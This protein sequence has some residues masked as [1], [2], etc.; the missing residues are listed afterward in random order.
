MDLTEV[1][2]ALRVDSSFDDSLIERYM[3]TAE[4]KIQS[5]VCKDADSTFFNGEKIKPLY[6]TCCIML[7]GHWYQN[8][9]IGSKY[10][11]FEIPFGVTS[12][13]HDLRGAYYLANNES[14]ST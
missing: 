14:I 11:T 6:E 3:T 12:F 10:E 7:V 8:R 2:N 5:A 4:L 13:I 1:K 9:F